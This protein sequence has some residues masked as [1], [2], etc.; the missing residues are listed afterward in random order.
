[1]SDRVGDAI[2]RDLNAI[3]DAIDALRGSAPSEGPVAYELGEAIRHVTAVRDAMAHSADH[4]ADCPN[5]QA[6]IKALENG[7]DEPYPHGPDAFIPFSM[8]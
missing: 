2:L 6:N 1:M 5:C 8:N 3:I 4:I 7:E